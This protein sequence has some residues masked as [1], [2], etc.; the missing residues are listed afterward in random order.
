MKAIHLP[1]TAYTPQVDFDFATHRLSLR[2]ESYPENAASFYQ[3]LIDAVAQY[4]GQL[5]ET[6]ITVDVA[7]AYFNS[8]S[9]KLLF[10]L[11][12]HLNQAALA[13]NDVSLNWHHDP[14]DDTI[15]EFGNELADDFNALE[16][17][18]VEIV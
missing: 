15:V 6:R 4:I 17:R 1:A 11:F 5:Q 2:G 16:L 13:G 14:E 18:L 9:T 7:L 12:G 3:P 10:S 8:S